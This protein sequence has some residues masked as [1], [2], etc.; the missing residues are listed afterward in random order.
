MATI[1]VMPLKN[2]SLNLI[3][4]NGKVVIFVNQ[5]ALCWVE[6]EAEGW[7][8]MRVLFEVDVR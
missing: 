8:L 6:T 4:C 5:T 1:G 3:E 7:E 2:G